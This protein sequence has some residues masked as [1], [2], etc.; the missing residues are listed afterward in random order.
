MWIANEKIRERRKKEFS[1]VMLTNTSE[2][3]N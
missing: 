2:S 3:I 1:L